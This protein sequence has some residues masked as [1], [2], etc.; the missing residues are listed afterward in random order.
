M[1]VFLTLC[2]NCDLF[3]FRD[4]F[5]QR[6]PSNVASVASAAAASAASPAVFALSKTEEEVNNT[7]I[8][9]LQISSRFELSTLILTRFLFVY[10]CV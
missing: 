6:A 8:Q 2:A 5:T 1:I 10:L 9:H 4:L 3:Q 7:L